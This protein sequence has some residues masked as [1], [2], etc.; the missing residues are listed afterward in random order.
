MQ[1]EINSSSSPAQLAGVVSKW[2]KLIAGQVNGLSDQYK[3]GGG[4][5]PEV[6]KLFGKAQA[7]AAAGA[8]APAGAVDTNNKWLK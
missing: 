8:R 7:S 4:N 1:E 6:M 3:S 2:Q 5:N